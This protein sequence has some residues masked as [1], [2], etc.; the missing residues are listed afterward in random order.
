MFLNIDFNNIFIADFY[1]KHAFL[2]TDY[3]S[4]THKQKVQG[5]L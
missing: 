5:S 1:Y 4:K 3:I 2:H